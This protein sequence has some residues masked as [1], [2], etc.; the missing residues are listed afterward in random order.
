MINR[1]LLLLVAVSTMFAA[2]VTYSYDAAGRLIKADYGAAGA[3]TYSYDKAG[4]LL[5][6]T[7]TSGSASAGTI[8]SV[9]TASSPASAGIAANTFIEIKGTS[10]VPANTPSTGVIWSNAPEFAQGKM[11]TNLQGVQVTVNGKPAYVYFF[12]SA[13][14]SACAVDQVNALTGL[15]ALSGSAQVV[16]INNGVPSAAFSANGKPLVPSLL[17]FNAQ[18]YVAATHLNFNLLGPTTL[19]PGASTPGNA[20]EQVILYAV[21]FGPTTTPQTEGSS[22]QSGSLATPLPVCKIGS[23]NAVVSFAGLIAP[24]LYQINITIPNPQPSGDNPINCTY[25]GAST[26][27]G[28]LITVK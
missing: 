26:Q 14:T 3:I 12:C 21:G 27:S 7:V 2:A 13:V 1:C 22:S 8:T 6:R 10:L 11:P 4:N 15:D 24:G 18:G 23:N 28:A 19:Y 17:L 16:V 25:N 9:N 20:G 5:S